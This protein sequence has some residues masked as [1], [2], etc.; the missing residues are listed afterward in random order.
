MTTDKRVHVGSVT[1]TVLAT[2]VL[3][4][5]TTGRI[6]LDTP[7]ADLLPGLGFDNPWAAS[8]PVRVRHLL[9]HTAGLDNLRFWQ[10][11]S[12]KP[13]IDTPLI[14]AFSRDPALLRVRT[15]PGSA[16]SYSSMGYGLL[17]L[18]IESVTGERY[19][20]YLDSNLLR[21]LSM[22]DSTFEFVSQSSDARL[23]M[24]HFEEG[25]T[26]A[27]VAVYLRPAGQ[28]TTTV[29]DMAVFAVNLLPFRLWT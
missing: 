24:G 11:F 2:G 15:R 18:V 4:L 25:Q 7:V 23:A 12:L 10:A 19:E 20:H 1:K 27:A 17:G 16:Y 14:E 26:Q 28:F 13:K 6:S 3:R 8:D 5:I 9:A 22:H 21:P 29:A